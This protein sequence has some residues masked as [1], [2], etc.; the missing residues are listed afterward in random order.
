MAR[1]SCIILVRRRLNLPRLNQLLR[2]VITAIGYMIV[3]VT[4]VSAFLGKF[5]VVL[6]EI[7]ETIGD[8]RRLG[9]FAAIYEVGWIEILIITLTF[10]AVVLLVY[11]YQIEPIDRLRDN[12]ND[13]LGRLRPEIKPK[14]PPKATNR[15]RTARSKPKASSSVPQA[16]SVPE[17]DDVDIPD[18]PKE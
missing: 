18:D 6:N 2:S 13:L 5:R 1:C 8:I 7:S 9:F 15:K 11:V 16:S 12:F 10:L 3:A 14:L 4:L 17:A